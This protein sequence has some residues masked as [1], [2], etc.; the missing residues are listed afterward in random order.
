[1]LGAVL[2]LLVVGLGAEVT[3]GRWSIHPVLSGSMRPGFPVGGIVITEREPLSRLQ[4]RDVIVTHPPGE[5]HF[6][7]IHRVIS[8]AS[9]TN[10]SV[11]AQTMGDANPAPDPFQVV[12][13]GP[14]MY[15]VKYSLPLLGYPALWAHSPGGR[16][17]FLAVAIGLLLVAALRSGWASTRKRSRGPAETRPA[18]GS[19][20]PAIDEEQLSLVLRLE[21]AT[22]ESARS[23]EMAAATETSA[24]G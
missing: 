7:L 14:W 11:T 5:P 15:Q 22:G 1:M 8:I 23:P 20:S 17:I 18:T 19:G 12:V 3:S 24:P 13:H 21:E 6:D 9:R 16:R 4:L 2:L 10:D